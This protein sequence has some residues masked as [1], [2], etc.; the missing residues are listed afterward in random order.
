MTAGR[1]EGKIEC[2]NQRAQSS[3]ISSLPS[4][5]NNFGHFASCVKELDNTQRTINESNE[6]G[7]SFLHIERKTL[8][9][10]WTPGKIVLSTYPFTKKFS[11]TFKIFFISKDDNI[12]V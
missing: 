11:L 12:S 5:K 1:G 9:G 6:H 8:I 7:H 4:I 2:H 3:A 10:F